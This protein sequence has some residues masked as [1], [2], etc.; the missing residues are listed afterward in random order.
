MSALV[1]GALGAKIG[2]VTN[3]GARI[4]TT[5]TADY[6]ATITGWHLVRAQ[7]AGGG[8]ETSAVGG[9]IGGQA[10][11]FVEMKHWL[12]AGTN[13]SLTVGVGGAAGNPAV[14]G[15]DTTFT[16]PNVTQTAKGG[17]GGYN[18][19]A[20]RYDASPATGSA[21]LNQLGGAIGGAMGGNTTSPNGGYCG[22]FLGGVSTASGGGGGAS[23][24]AAGGAPG[25]AG[26]L[27]SGGG[28]GAT[29]GAGGNGVIEI[30]FIGTN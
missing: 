29:A 24:F 21:A 9:Y 25:A 10:G 14:A 5:G 26:T 2:A 27:G 8:G 28:A 19:S 20:A 13:Y 30:E 22:Q 7:G 1:I 6:T 23:V 17:S 18:G 4:T 3:R 15:G 12:V 16:G 11:M